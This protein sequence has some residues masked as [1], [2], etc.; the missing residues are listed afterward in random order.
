M[1]NKRVQILLGRAGFRLFEGFEIEGL[2]D[3]L[4]YRLLNNAM[5]EG[6]IVPCRADGG[7]YGDD[8]KN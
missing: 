5:R 6:A 7:H 8:N 2:R 4:Y 1:K 3:Q